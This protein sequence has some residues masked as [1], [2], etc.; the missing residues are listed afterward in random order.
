MHI[1]LAT[2]REIAKAQHGSLL[3]GHGHMAHPPGALIRK[4]EPDHFVVREGRTVEEDEVGAAQSFLQPAGNLGAPRNIKE[5]L[6]PVG[7]LEA[8]RLFAFSPDLDVA[9]LEIKRLF[10]GY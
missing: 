9:T 2:D 4:A 6:R 5:S 3:A 7:N 1:D 8:E 10:A